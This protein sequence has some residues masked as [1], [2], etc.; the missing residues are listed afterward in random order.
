MQV[1]FL[2]L[3]PVTSVLRV[4]RQRWCVCVLSSASCFSLPP[5]WAL[6]F[7]GPSVSVL[8]SVH[9]A[10]SLSS[11]GQ[12]SA[13]R[14]PPPPVCKTVLPSQTQSPGHLQSCPPWALLLVR[15]GLQLVTSSYFRHPLFSR[16]HM[17]P[18]FPLLLNKC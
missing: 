10:L 16:H 15:F 5:T 7:L 18:I 11:S 2:Y 13:H 4:E 9:S 1:V 12:S 17:S 6:S 8:L 14:G 3:S